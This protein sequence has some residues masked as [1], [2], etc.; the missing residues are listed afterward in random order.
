MKCFWDVNE[1]LTRCYKNA[2]VMFQIDNETLMT[3]CWDIIKKQ[4]IYTKETSKKNGNEFVRNNIAE[5]RATLCLY[6]TSLGDK[7]FEEQI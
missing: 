2:N 5:L 4:L 6:L 7:F 3:C 1:T